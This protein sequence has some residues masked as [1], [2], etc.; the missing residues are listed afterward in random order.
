MLTECYLN[1]L[2][3][4]NS[5]LGPSRVVKPSP[6]VMLLPSSAGARQWWILGGVLG[7]CWLPVVAEREGRL[8]LSAEGPLTA[9]PFLSLLVFLAFVPQCPPRAPSESS[10]A[11][12]SQILLQKISCLP[13]AAEEPLTPV[14]SGY[15]RINL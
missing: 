14:S 11:S 7:V 13:G 1:T 10:A 8:T 12:P 5:L 6:S 15:A 2:N 3:G 9:L 4:G